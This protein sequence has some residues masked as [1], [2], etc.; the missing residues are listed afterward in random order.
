VSLPSDLERLGD[1]LE[2]AA[3]RSVRRR[4]RLQLIRNAL[5]ALAIALPVMLAVATTVSHAP[6]LPP[7]SAMDDGLSTFATYSLIP[8]AEFGGRRHVPDS[9]LPPDNPSSCSDG[10]DCRRPVPP[11]RLVLYPDPARRA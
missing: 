10:N 9:W 8:A 2:V 11:T 5:C 4:A 3:L 6:V 7:A 1:R